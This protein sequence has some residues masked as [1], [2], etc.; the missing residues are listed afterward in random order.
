MPNRPRIDYRPRPDATP[1]DEV[2]VLADAYAFLIGRAEHN[3]DPSRAGGGDET[4]GD[5][6]GRH[7]EGG[8]RV[9]GLEHPEPDPPT[10]AGEERLS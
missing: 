6:T 4:E 5:R 1:E 8:Q 10:R 9:T 2:R 3:P 7:A